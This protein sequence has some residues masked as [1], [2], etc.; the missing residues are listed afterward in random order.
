VAKVA[1]SEPYT[2]ADLIGER[3]PWKLVQRYFSRNPMTYSADLFEPH[4]QPD[5]LKWQPA[6]STMAKLHDRF[7][8]WKHAAHVGLL[9]NGLP[10][11]L[12]LTDA[13]LNFC[14]KLP[15]EQRVVHYFRD[16]LWQ[17]LMLRYMHQ[18]NLEQTVHE[19]L[20]GELVEPVKMA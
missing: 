1:R 10:V 14:N 12:N 18:Q 7:A 20:T 11:S 8:F 5:D 15:Y 16:H 13:A 3:L 2:Q 19:Q 4:V 6:E 17:E 9:D